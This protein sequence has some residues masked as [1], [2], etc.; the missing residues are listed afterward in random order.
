[1][2]GQV[3]RFLWLH[4]ERS[5]L[6]E[7]RL[8]DIQLGESVTLGVYEQNVAVD[9]PLKLVCHHDRC[10]DECSELPTRVHGNED[11]AVEEM[12][13]NPPEPEPRVERPNLKVHQPEPE[14]APKKVYG[15][16]D[17]DIFDDALLAKMMA[18]L[19]SHG[20]SADD[21]FG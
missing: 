1:M 20:M 15:Q 2:R 3:R 7:V 16:V 5:V 6:S 8:A 17:D 19:A 12:I 18:N 10:E 9:T 4:V 14:P 11:E 21:I 13:V